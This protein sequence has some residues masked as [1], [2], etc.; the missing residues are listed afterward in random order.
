MKTVKRK[1]KKKRYKYGALTWSGTVN[2]TEM[3]YKYSF[4]IYCLTMQLPH[5]QLDLHP[6][7]CKLKGIP[8]RSARWISFILPVVKNKSAN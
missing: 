4:I 5:I 2:P 1:K 3:S 7:Y 6:N 8:N